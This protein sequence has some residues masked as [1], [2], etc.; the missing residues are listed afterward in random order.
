MCSWRLAV[1]HQ[2]ARPADALT[3]VRVERHRLD[4]GGSQA[5]VDDVE[6]LQER[7]LVVDPRRVDDVEV[8]V[9]VGAVLT[10]EAQGEV[11][12]RRHLSGSPLALASW[13]S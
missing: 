12:V 8:T 2:R 6:H 1:D 4:S 9:V 10:P 11:E 5:L 13:L 7:H 3:A